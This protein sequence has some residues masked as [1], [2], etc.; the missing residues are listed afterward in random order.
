MFEL[1]TYLLV[2]L[3]TYF[4]VGQFR[5]WSLKNEIFDVP[6][7][8]SSHQNPTPRGGGLIIVLVCLIFYAVLSI[9][10]T[11][12]FAWGYFAGAV[13]VAFI[14]WLDDLYT[15]SFIWRFLVHTIAAC[16]LIANLGF[17]TE[18]HLPI[19]ENVEFG[20][21]GAIISFLWIVWLTNAYNFMDGIDGIAGMQAFTAGIGWLFVGKM[22]GMDSTAIYGGVLAFSAVGFL[23][24]N[25]H[26]AKIFMG[27][28]GS[29]FL[30]FTFAALPFIAKSENSKNAADI[31]LIAI[32]LVWLFVF[33]TVFTFI[34][35]LLKKQKVWTA[36]RE[37]L[38]QK[39]V[40]AG[41]SHQFVAGLYGILSLVTVF[42]IFFLVQ[43]EKKYV[44]L[45]S[46]I[47]LIEAIVI[48]LLN[49]IDKNVD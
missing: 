4:G 49:S 2:F 27:D 12:N 39:L 33:D 24:H 18:I 14:S 47:C 42:F 48:F 8:R 3:L 19:F 34:R 15:I 44:T 28:V 23:I 13:L 31:P 26:P 22:F 25:W 32:L 46:S 17:W 45:L 30:G 10:F 43:T 41:K 9:F 7:E 40:I 16:L 36:H 1:L 20:Y 21:Y 38:Y 35:R 37:H 11:D 29:A 5:R 6:N